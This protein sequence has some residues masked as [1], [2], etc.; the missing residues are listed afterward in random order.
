MSVKLHKEYGVNTTISQCIICGKDKNEIVLLGAA[1]KKEAPIYMVTSIEPCD[2][3]KE[4]YL[5]QGVLL[6]ECKEENNKKIPTGSI[7]VIKDEAFSNIFNVSIP[8][9]KIAMVE[10]GVL[11][12]INSMVQ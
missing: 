1:Y 12:K 11:E 2:E 8:K 5:S 7:T 9:G 3:C 10:V 4:K 6:V